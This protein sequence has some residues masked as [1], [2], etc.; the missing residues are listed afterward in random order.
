MF[1]GSCVCVCLSVCGVGA[2]VQGVYFERAPYCNNIPGLPPRNITRFFGLG[3]VGNASKEKWLYAFN[4]EP[5]SKL[6]VA[7]VVGQRPTET[8]ANP[9]DTGSGIQ[10]CFGDACYVGYSG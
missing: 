2:G 6:E 3:A 1:S 4:C 9:Y 10:V 5:M 8:T 7:E